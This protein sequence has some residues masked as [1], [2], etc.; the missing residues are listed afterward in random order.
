MAPSLQMTDGGS[1]LIAAPPLPLICLTGHET[2]TAAWTG[3]AL[4]LVGL[5]GSG[6]E[7]LS[8]VPESSK[9]H[10]HAKHPHNNDFERD[11]GNQN[12]YAYH[13]NE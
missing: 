4:L 10:D 11:A 5:N 2:S 7:S 8:D 12:G 13:G 6:V 3:L 9:H 1:V